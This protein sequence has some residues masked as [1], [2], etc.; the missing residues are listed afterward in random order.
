MF[1]GKVVIITGSSSGIGAGTAI[2]FAQEKAKGIVLHG[3]NEKSLQEVKSQCEQAGQNEVKI[4]TCV[5]DITDEGVR[6]NIIDSTIAQFGQLDIMINNAGICT[7]DDFSN[8]AM[9]QYDIIFNVNVR[10]VMALTQLAIPH[11]IES[12]GNI[13]NISSIGGMKASPIA[14][15]YCC[16]KA[17]LDHF[18]KCLALELGPKGIRVN[19]VNPAYVAGTEIFNRQNG[20]TVSKEIIKGLETYATTTYPL[21]RSGQL[22][23]VADAIAYLSSDKAAFVTGTIMPID[24][25]FALM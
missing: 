21:R 12:R 25:G 1:K 11:L 13:V 24:G 5:G 16:S 17:T 9:D 7:M 20:G 3:R 10:S 23:D 15:F 22:E 6:K 18:T 2:K 14:T 19:S 4:H 8:T